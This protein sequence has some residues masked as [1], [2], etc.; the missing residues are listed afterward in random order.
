MRDKQKF[1]TG[2][3]VRNYSDLSESEL[4]TIYIIF[5]TSPLFLLFLLNI[6]NF[7]FITKFILIVFWISIMALG[8]SLHILAWI[9]RRDTGTPEMQKIADSISEGAEGFFRAQYGTIFKLSFIFAMAIMFLNYTKKEENNP[10][11]LVIS[12][13][14]MAIFSGISFMFG[15]FS[16]ASSGYAG[17]W[18]SVRTNIR[19][20]KLYLF[21][22]NFYRVASAAR[23]DYN[24]ALELAFKGGYFSAI[25]NIALALF[26]ICLMFLLFL[27]YLNAGQEVGYI[28]PIEKIPL[29]M[30]GFGFGASFVAMFAQLGGGIF[31][32]AA[33]V[34]ADL[35]GMLLNI[36]NIKI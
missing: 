30:I 20:L 35:V 10:I 15:A 22:I 36:F 25:I 32:K 28:A 26:G 9:M 6:L 17:M 34:G 8:F 4:K 19:Y 24:E 5:W 16:S 29:L 27:I 14:W 13:F 21:I 7:N 11:S 23:R 1:L 18:V 33:D 2:T 3:L 31:T 12:N